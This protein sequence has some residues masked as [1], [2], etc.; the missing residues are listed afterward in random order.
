MKHRRPTMREIERDYYEDLFEHRRQVQEIY[1][2]PISSWW[3]LLIIAAGLALA[4]WL[5]LRYP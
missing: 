2:R 1:D 5:D 4:Y 3:G